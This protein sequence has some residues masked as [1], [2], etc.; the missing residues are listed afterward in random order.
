MAAK[1]L[2]QRYSGYEGEIVSCVNCSCQEK[3][4]V[5]TGHFDVGQ[6]MTRLREKRDRAEQM[7]AEWP[8]STRDNIRADLT[9][10]EAMTM[11]EAIEKAQAALLLLV[12]IMEH[13]S[14]L[15]ANTR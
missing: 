15:P 2:Y 12:P 3:P 7:Y 1:E 11:V 13:L 6:I 5:A 14:S 10:F 4:A 9:I 8:Q